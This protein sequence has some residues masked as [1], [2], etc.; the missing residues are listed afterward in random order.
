MNNN[1]YERLAQRLDALPN[2]FPPTADGAELQLLAKLFTA[3]EAAL[4][5][6]LRLT[7]ETPQEIAARVGGDARIIRRHLKGMVRRGLISWDRNEG[8]IVYGLLPFVV[9]I[10]EM[11]AGQIDRELAELFE[12]YY[13]QT[14]GQALSVQPQFHRVIPVGESIGGGLEIRP[15]DSAAAIV[16][17]ASAWGVTDCICRKQKALIGDACQ[18][19]LDVC[20]VFS[21]LP[22]YFEGN[23]AIRALTR[24]E[25]L[26]TLR[27]A[28]EAGLVHSVSNNQRGLWYI[29]NCCTCSC[30]ILRGIAEQGIADV[31][32][33]SA[34]VN[35]VDEGLCVACGDCLSSCQ[36]DA[37]SLNE[38]AEIEN[39]RCVGCGVCVLACPE[40]ALSLVPRAAHE[41]SPPPLDN[42]DWMI[43]RAIARG[44][45][46]AEVL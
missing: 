31:V 46:L 25:A 10:Y 5:A 24:E 39:K 16:D 34:F 2:G 12:A 11:Q 6:E 30:G 15:Y 35:Q 26:G 23:S 42:K 22:G 3:E 44:R 14:F 7:K 8:G 36:F 37:L 20:M 43:Q 28:A 19:P 1:P 33:R 38:F 27:R 40:D 29:C 21:K 18:H 4:A 17:N 32:A 45:N 41:V 9:G 13:L